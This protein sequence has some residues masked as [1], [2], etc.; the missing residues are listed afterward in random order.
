ME[1]KTGNGGKRERIGR[2]VEEVREERARKRREKEGR[3]G[4][5]RVEEEKG[6]ADSPYQLLPVSLTIK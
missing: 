1:G 6:R 3:G 4:K 2:E 5:S